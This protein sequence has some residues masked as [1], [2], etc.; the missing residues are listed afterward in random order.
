[1]T[2]SRRSAMLTA[3]ALFT[4]ARPARAGVLA[5]FATE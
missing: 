1:M 5:G 3:A 2:L 4:G